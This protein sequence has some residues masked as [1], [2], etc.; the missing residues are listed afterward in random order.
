VRT[1][2]IALGLLLTF[3]IPVHAQEA[4]DDADLQIA[5]T[6]SP[7]IDAPSL[8]R[9]QAYL[10]KPPK[11]VDTA[12]VG[13]SI[14]E[15]WAKPLQGT[16]R[17]LNLGIISDR[18]QRVLWRLNSPRLHDFTP[19][20][21][22]VIAGTNNLEIEKTCAIVVG[23][24][25]LIRK[26]HSIWPKA[27]V[28]VVGLLPRGVGFKEFPDKIRTVN[29]ELHAVAPKEQFEFR[30]LGEELSCHWTQPCDNYRADNLHLTADGNQV[31]SNQLLR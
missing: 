10:Q 9:F 28:L 7:P 16:H 14:A 27:S 23:L 30:D 4:C 13:D 26:I 24:T 3:T 1:L 2:F 20:R 31:L 8:R 29:A 25:I 12:I 21:V 6:P 11:D 19:R 17:I 22:V 5:E 18:I 15:L